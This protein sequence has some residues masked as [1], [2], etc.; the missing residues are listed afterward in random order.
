MI[1]EHWPLFG[2][3]LRT[4]RLE[5]RVPDL[6]DLAH[7]ADVAA[8]GVHD[9]GYQPFLVPWT[10]D[11]PQQVAR[12]T[13][14]FHWRMLGEWAP[15]SWSLNLVTLFDGQVIGTQ[16]LDARQFAT[17]REVGTGSWL[18]RAHHGKGFGT[19]MRA[20]VLDLAFAGLGAQW[21]VSEAFATNAASYGVSRRLGYVDD[22]VARHVVRGE[23]VVGRRLR[24]DRAGWA[25][26]RTV[27]VRIEGLAPCLPM[28]GC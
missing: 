22:G 12:G 10:D 5:L 18:G 13:L 8:E 4:P 26:A 15:E 11:S 19:E 25:A 16:A 6:T 27:D 20:A 23:A 14:Q 3:R 9:P 28:F 17:L 7:L 21:A 2:L 1:T 24:L